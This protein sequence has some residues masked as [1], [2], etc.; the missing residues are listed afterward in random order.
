MIKVQHIGHECPAGPRLPRDLG[1]AWDLGTATAG[2]PAA[3]SGVADLGAAG[4]AAS[5]PGGGMKLG[6]GIVPGPAVPIEKQ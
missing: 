2:P 3:A 1:A 6:G 5:D 4:G